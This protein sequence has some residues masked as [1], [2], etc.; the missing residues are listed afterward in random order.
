MP[1]LLLIAL[2]LGISYSFDVVIPTQVEQCFYEDLAPQTLIVGEVRSK[3]PSKALS[4]KVRDPT[5]LLLF[6]KSQVDYAKFS[7]T[8]LESGIY[9]ICVLNSGPAIATSVDVKTGVNAKDYSAIASTKELKDIELKLRKLE[10]QTKQIHTKV[11]Y[12]REREEEMRGTNQ[13]IHNRVIGYSICTLVFLVALALVQI[14]Y[15]KRFFR[16][17]KM[18]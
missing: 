9:Q 12:L 6:E 18:I 8:S 7:F 11:Q 10:D 16:A 5:D 1:R 4:V 3:N 2:L 15:L 17:K 13:T 14:L